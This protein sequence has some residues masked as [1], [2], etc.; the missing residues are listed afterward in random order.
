MIVM[1]HL[2]VNRKDKKMCL[3]PNIKNS[4]YLNIFSIIKNR[5]EQHNQLFT[6]NKQIIFRIL[7]EYSEHLSVDDI[8]NIALANF[9]QKLN[10]STVYRIMSA[11]EVLGIVDNIIV[12]DKKRFELIYFR[13]PHYH[14][15][16]QEC[17]NVIEFESLEIH[18]LFL[19]EL[20][21]IDFKP[22]NF[23]VII[24]G[25]CKKCQN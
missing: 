14:L 13:Q 9:K 18:N 2:S 12:D 20:D 7:Y 17:N 19:K 22:T 25:V 10:S 8:V 21:K 4:E 3:L 1:L 11:F 6:I 5:F 24:N 16:C 15:Y 23:N